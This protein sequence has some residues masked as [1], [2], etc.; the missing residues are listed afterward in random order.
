MVLAALLCYESI[1]QFAES[2]FLDRVIVPFMEDEMGAF[3]RGQDV[4]TKIGA[5][6]L[7]P[8]RA[9]GG[10]GF[11]HREVSVPPEIGGGIAEGGFAQH[12]ETLDIPLL[13][14]GLLS[15]DIDGEVEKVGD[16]EAMLFP[17]VTVSSLEDVQALYDEDA[18]AAYHL[19]FLRD[20]VIGEVGI[21]GALTEGS[22]DLISA[23]KRTRRCR[24]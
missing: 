12:Q 3:P 19:H 2:N 8:D 5:V 14:V 20:N 7:L 24:S 15:I 23:R 22:P 21:D 11:L 17:K 4:L 1:S 9:G 18:R 6:D 16:E 10:N 13:D